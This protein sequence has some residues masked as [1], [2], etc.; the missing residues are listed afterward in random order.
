MNF[1]RIISDL[2]KQ[3]KYMNASI[4]SKKSMQEVY[5]QFKKDKESMAQTLKN[6]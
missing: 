2:S 1:E 6:D 4:V 5:E 3:D